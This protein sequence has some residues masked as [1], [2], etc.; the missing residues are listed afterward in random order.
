[1]E[2]GALHGFCSILLK[3]LNK[4]MSREN[5]IIVAI[6]F[7][8]ALMTLA[9]HTLKTVASEGSSVSNIVFQVVGN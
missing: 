3:Q 8:A 1:M 2:Y 7:Y 5:R 6:A 4:V 9:F